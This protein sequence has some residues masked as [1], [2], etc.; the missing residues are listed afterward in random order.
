MQEGYKYTYIR[1]Y[2]YKR[3]I[4]KYIKVITNEGCAI[5]VFSFQNR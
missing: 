1:K 2:T 4:Q 3:L 5:C